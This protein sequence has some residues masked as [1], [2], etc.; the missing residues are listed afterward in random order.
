ME[1]LAPLTALII[2]ALAIYVAIS[3]R[4]RLRAVLAAAVLPVLAYPTI[5]GALLV[6][7]LAVAVY[8]STMDSGRPVSELLTDNP[9][10]GWE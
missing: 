10:T 9:V 1:L 3:M 5:L 7:I 2:Q 4:L 6:A 8:E